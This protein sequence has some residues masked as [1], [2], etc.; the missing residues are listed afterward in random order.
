MSK[1][2]PYPITGEPVRHSWRDR[3]PYGKIVVGAAVILVLIAATAIPAFL[4]S[5]A[6]LRQHPMYREALARAQSN[7]RVIEVLGEPIQPG[8]YFSGSTEVRGQ[9]GYADFEI[10]LHGSK[11]HG[12][13]YVRT[14][15]VRGQ[16]EFRR[17]WLEVEGIRSIDL[18][19]PQPAKQP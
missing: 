5:L 16:W 19:A 13:L 15:Q 4:A 7:P 10:P 2:P 12:D 1:P 11:N 8:R 14:L 9:F 3:H 17:L 18:L 6:L